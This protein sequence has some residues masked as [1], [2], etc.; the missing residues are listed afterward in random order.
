MHEKHLKAPL[1]LDTHRAGLISIL[2]AIFAAE[3]LSPSD[4][5]QLVR[6]QARANGGQLY[7]RDELIRAYRTYAGT[8]GLPPFDGA[9]IQRLRLKPVR[10]SSGVTPVTVLTKPFPCP[11]ECIFCPNDVRMP[12]S[13]LSDEP[14]AQRA[15]QNSFDPYL[16]TMSR[17]TA[18][19]NIGHPTEKIEIIILGGTWSF[20]PETYQLW[21]VKRIFDALHDYGA[22]ID[23]SVKIEGMLF[24]QSQLH[25]LRN[26][27]HVDVH[28]EQLDKSYNQIVQSIYEAE[29]HRSRDVM[30]HILHD[31]H[32]R[33]PLDEYATWDELEAAHRF[34]ETAPS[35]CVG[36]VIETRPDQISAEE[37]LRV[38]R[39]G[40]T[41]VQIG[42]QSLNDTVL[43]MNRRGHNVAATRRAVRLL[44]SAGF[45]IHAH[46]MPNLYGSSP[47]ADV[48][49]YQRMFDDPDF[50]PDELKIYPCSLIESAELM[51]HYKNGTWEPYSH[52]ALLDTL[53][54]CL[55]ATPE[56]CRLTR[57]IRDI[58]GTDI[59][60]GN[61]L[62]NFRQIVEDTLKKR[63]ERSRD[64]RAR[65]V[66]YQQV[67]A[68]DLHLDEQWYDGGIGQEVFL[69]FIT[70][71]REI[72]GFLRL[73]LPTCDP[74][75]PE[76]A[77]AAMIREVHV[78]GQAIDIGEVSSG[79]A[80][81]AGLGTQLIE[82]A[83][84]LAQEHGYDRLAVISAVGTR[85]YY[86]K[87]GF[88][89]G[90]LYQMRTL[91]TDSRA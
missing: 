72:A 5:N 2:K 46:W 22:G 3:T 71:T 31:G 68:G 23:R 84:A 58:P 76:L 89:D 48:E 7:S 33:S 51:R 53:I 25:P 38:R 50:R 77:G 57:I 86:R 47:Q 15:E 80:Q 27:T 4:L 34:N 24:E 17:L 60:D 56:Y 78:Y 82:R 73:S 1:D 39:L 49:D 55:R 74:I 12:K 62:T 45:K 42:F 37:V 14:G 10:T 59:V 19:Y 64:I 69:Q 52:Q 70:D 8:D 11:G 79:K 88:I 41:K 91:T 44:R 35:R 40:C 66:R 29:M 65:E 85:A 32:E 13:Y 61:K 67:V 75:T 9:L 6:N 87:R 21:F 28:G 20:Y 30:T 90:V 83:A 36:L 18:Y 26:T 54:E 43:K 81:H 63:G 16:Q